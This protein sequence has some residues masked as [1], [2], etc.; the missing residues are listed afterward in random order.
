MLVYTPIGS[1]SK[2]VKYFILAKLERTPSVYKM[3]SK[4]ILMRQVDG[5]KNTPEQDD[6][7]IKCRMA[8]YGWAQ[9]F[10][11][12]GWLNKLLLAF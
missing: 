9:N 11:P 3:S 10:F 8:S 12:C 5:F 1:S 7:I 2:D 6:Y 4:G